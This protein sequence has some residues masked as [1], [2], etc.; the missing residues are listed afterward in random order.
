M[1]T[2]TGH[3]RTSFYA[4]GDETR[5]THRFI[6]MR[7]N[8]STAVVRRNVDRAAAAAAALRACAQQESCGRG[9]FDASGGRARAAIEIAVAARDAPRQLALPDL[10]QPVDRH[11]A[12][13]RAQ[14]EGGGSARAGRA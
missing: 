5:M 2:K 1:T 10:A 3:R 9:R 4:F 12:R 8:G 7:V 14:G 11:S 13:A 6:R